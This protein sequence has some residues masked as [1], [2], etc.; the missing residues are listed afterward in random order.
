MLFSFD[1]K[2]EDLFDDQDKEIVLDALV[3]IFYKVKLSS[4]LTL[5]K[6]LD[7]DLWVKYLI[8]FISEQVKNQITRD[9]K[10]KLIVE[11]RIWESARSF[12]EPF[13][14][15]ELKLTVFFFASLSIKQARFIGS[16]RGIAR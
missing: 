8:I 13:H 11:I 2:L 14:E 1:N 3:E 12:I 15:F 5:F 16:L 4:F 7:N 9:T 6:V 10:I